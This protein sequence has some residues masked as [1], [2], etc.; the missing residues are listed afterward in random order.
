MGTWPSMPMIFLVWKMCK[1]QV[2][3]VSG[4]QSGLRLTKTHVHNQVTV[5]IAM[6]KFTSLQQP[7]IRKSCMKPS[8]TSKLLR[9]ISQNSTWT[10]SWLST[11]TCS[12]LGVLRLLDFHHSTFQVRMVASLIQQLTM[13]MPLMTVMTWPW[14]KITSMAHLRTS[15]TSFVPSTKTVF[16]PLLTGCQTKSITSLEKKW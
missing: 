11:L 3:S 6:V 12:K 14:V 4:Y 1:Y 2:T 9:T 7:L 13:V 8:Q 5:P 16:K 10:V 15:L